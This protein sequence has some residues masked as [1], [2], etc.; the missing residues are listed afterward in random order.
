VTEFLELAEAVE[1]AEF[2]LPIG[3]STSLVWYIQ[4]IVLWYLLLLHGTWYC[5]LH[6]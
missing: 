5:Y 6:Y 1:F 3:T 2:D 4:S